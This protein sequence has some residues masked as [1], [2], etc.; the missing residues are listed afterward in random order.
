MVELCIAVGDATHVPG[1]MARLAAIFDR[2]SLAFDRS[3]KEVRV[4]S[5]WESRGV[6]QVVD[7]VA[8]W[9]A[10]NGAESATLSLGNKSYTMPASDFART[11]Q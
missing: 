3:R 11:G 9:L 1:L 10:E 4:S 8:S 7:A 5:E 2:S 6:A